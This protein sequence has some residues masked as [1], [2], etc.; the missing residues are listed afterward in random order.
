M[1]RSIGDIKRQRRQHRRWR[2]TA[3]R[4][5]A[6]REREEDAARRLLLNSLLRQLPERAHDEFFRGLAEGLSPERAKENALRHAA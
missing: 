3:N 2:V 6:Q 4:R 1:S 5:R